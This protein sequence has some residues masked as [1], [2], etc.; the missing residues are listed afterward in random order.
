MNADSNTES[1]KTITERRAKNHVVDLVISSDEVHTFRRFVPAGKGDM[2]TEEGGN[3]SV[4]LNGSGPRVPLT[5]AWSRTASLPLSPDLTLTVK[6][7]ET[8]EEMAGYRRLTQFHYRG[9]GGAGR[10]VPLV[11]V[12]ENWQLPEV[13]GFIELASSFIVNSARTKVLDAPFSDSDSGVAWSCW[14]TK[15]GKKFGNAFVR[16]SRCVVY[17][18][19]RGVGLSQILV[20]AAVAYARLRWH[21]AGMRPVFIEITAEMLRY[22]P[23][24]KKSGFH[25]VGDTEGNSHR[26]AADMRY[27]LSRKRGK[28]MPKGGGGIMSAQRAYATALA[29]VMERRRMT[30]GEIVQLLQ[31][32]PDSL[33]DDEW[34]ALHKVFRRPKPTY[35]LGLTPSAEQF[36]ARRVGMLRNAQERRSSSR[37]TPKKR[38]ASGQHLLTLQHLSLESRAFPDSSARARRVQEAFGIVAKEFSSTLVTPFDLSVDRGDIVLVMGPSGSGKS[39]LVRAI[40]WH[41]AQGHARGRL[42][43][44]VNSNASLDGPRVKVAWPRELDG[45]ISPIELL[46]SKSVDEALEVLATAGLAEADIFVRP[47][48]TLSMGQRYRLKIARAI[49]EEPDLLLVDEFC[50]P[51]DHFTA[52]AVS[53]RLR[54]AAVRRGLTAIVATADPARVI[55]NLKPDL[56]IRLSSDGSVEQFSDLHEAL[57]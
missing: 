47:A 53:R 21:L 31:Q 28:G 44:G 17:P 11:A 34:V 4:V 50:E 56:V 48:R 51:L 9:A 19:V 55:D 16:I 18:E 39:L 15:T 7:I 46:A 35:M 40:R 25:Y 52:V 12:V 2:L 22:W 54:A 10:K 33:T 30:I 5:P 24:V 45:A 29:E 27:L 38:P 8:P 36:L 26:A 32:A 49:A 41:V 57:A 42:P 14:D 13:I 3:F 37:P 20:D 43:D 6:E 23:F 1:K